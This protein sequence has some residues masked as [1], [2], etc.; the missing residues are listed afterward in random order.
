MKR[1]DG[2]IEH[3]R[4]RRTSVK[5]E[6]DVNLVPSDSI[7]FEASF[8]RK[9]QQAID[10]MSYRQAI[11]SWTARR[12]HDVVELIID[13]SNGKSL[14]DRAWIVFYWVTQ[15]IEYDVEAYF[16]GNIRHQTAED[17]F[18][19]GKGVCDGFGTIF[20][21]LCTAVQ[22]ECKKI[23]GYAKGYSFKMEQNSFARTNHAWNVIRLVG[24]WYLVD[25]T[26]GQGFLDTNNR[27]QKK[28]NPFY[29]L[30]RPE[31]MIYRHFPENS[32]WQ[33]LLSPISMDDFFRLPYADPVFFEH[34]LVIIFPH[35]S[36]T[37]S[38]NSNLGLAEVI[39]QTPSDT[40]LM[41]S[42]EQ[43]GSG[44]IKN[45]CFVQYDTSRQQWQ[46]L[47]APQQG[48][49]HT[50][51]LFVRRREKQVIESKTD[52]KNYSQAIQ[53]GLHVPTGVIRT[54]TFPLTYG[55]FTER[56]CQIFEPLDGVLKSGSIVTI[57]CRIPGAHC[58]R[59][60]LDENWLPE[61]LVKDEIFKRQITVPPKKI[62]MYVKFLDKQN[63][64]SYDGL[65]CYSVK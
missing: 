36:N 62:T 46:C 44:K 34:N 3:N 7:A 47:F 63:N 16:S 37:A 24:H 13:L 55:L 54:K 40:V 15:N 53:F 58:A 48:G 20:E 45:G 18:A 14:I 59:L 29:F 57:H 6:N 25:S 38:F 12:L 28:L 50:L 51:S 60:L 64:S 39:V 8:C 26:W 17:V 65:F 56:K 19:S 61:D 2:S 43:K 42:I 49:F 30:V 33:L 52:E 32:A 9:R 4:K 1:G 23:S 5:K 10:N 35:C 11:N 27:N 41:G 21:T 31:Q 22:I